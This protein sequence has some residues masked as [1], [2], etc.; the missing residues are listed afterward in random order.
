MYF[1]SSKLSGQVS[2]HARC[3]TSH[4][5][6]LVRIQPATSD[7]ANVKRCGEPVDTFGYEFVKGGVIPCREQ[8]YVY[9]DYASRSGGRR[10]LFDA[11]YLV[12]TIGHGGVACE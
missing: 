6:C 9:E 8:I 1:R 4:C 10:S 12:R 5:F 2:Y 3:F 7:R 11:Q